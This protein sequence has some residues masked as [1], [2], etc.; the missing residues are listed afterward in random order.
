MSGD[1]PPLDGHFTLKVAG[2]PSDEVLRL[3]F[4]TIAE[5]AGAYRCGPMLALLIYC[6]QL[7]SSEM[8]AFNH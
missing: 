3:P 5:L 8:T 6:L 1:G 7:E 2:G 4:A